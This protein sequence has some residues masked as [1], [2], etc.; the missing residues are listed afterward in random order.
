MLPA[1]DNNLLINVRGFILLGKNTT[2]LS[3][4]RADRRVCVLGFVRYFTVDLFD[5]W[6]AAV[7]DK[8]PHSSYLI[9]HSLSHALGQSLVL[10]LDV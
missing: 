6:E 10:F 9:P 3:I 4:L 2:S 8:V 1:L 7:L 5:I